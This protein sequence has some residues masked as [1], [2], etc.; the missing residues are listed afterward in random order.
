MQRNTGPA[1]RCMFT[2]RC[3]AFRVAICLVLSTDVTVNRC[4]IA[5]VR[6]ARLLSWQERLAAL[7]ELLLWDHA[8]WLG[9]RIYTAAQPHNKVF[10]S[11]VSWQ[12]VSMFVLIN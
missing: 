10:L 11:Q 4:V 8:L 6:S 3:I 1:L 2:A 9:L 5:G 7:R 12:Y